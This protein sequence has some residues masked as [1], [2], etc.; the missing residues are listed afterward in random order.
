MM[1]PWVLSKT[2]KQIS[3]ATSDEYKVTRERLDTVMYLTMDAA[4]MSAI[5]MQP[6]V[7]IAAT[8][9]LSYFGVPANKRSLTEATLFADDNRMMGAVLSNTK[10]FVAF[11]KVHK[12]RTA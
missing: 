8:K 6:V 12:T 9:V 10:S 7:P 1:E 2:L 5:L 4:R 11:P 3:D